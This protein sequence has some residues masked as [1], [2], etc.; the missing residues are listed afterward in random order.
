MSLPE[1]KVTKTLQ[2]HAERCHL[3]FIPLKK[4]GKKRSF[5]SIY[6]PVLLGGSPLLMWWIP[7]FLYMAIRGLLFQTIWCL[8]FWNRRKI[9]RL[10]QFPKKLPP[11]LFSDIFQFSTIWDFFFGNCVNRSIFVRNQKTRHQNV[12]KSNPLL[13]RSQKIGIHHIRGGSLSN[14][15]WTIF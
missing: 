11:P 2:N 5:S 8:L 10:T 12:Q 15:I 3:C 4:F 1:T 14:F 9:E 13:S 6:F 7:F